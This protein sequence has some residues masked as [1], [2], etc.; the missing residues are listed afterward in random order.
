M[1]AMNIVTLSWI[2]HTR[3][4]LQEPQQ[5]ITN[6][7]EVAKPGKVQD[8]TIKTDTGKADQITIS[9]L[10]ASQLELS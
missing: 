5:F 8:T 7:P 2:V 9:F 3:Y 10:N 4:L 6:L 1:S